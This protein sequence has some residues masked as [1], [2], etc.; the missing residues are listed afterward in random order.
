MTSGSAQKNNFPTD[1][2]IEA[3]QSQLNVDSVQ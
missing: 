2:E 3:F 1:A